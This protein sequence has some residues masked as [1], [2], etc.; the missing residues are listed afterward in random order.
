[1]LGQQIGDFTFGV[2]LL[3]KVAVFVFVFAVEEMTDAFQNSYGICFCRGVLS[4]IDQT[5]VQFV[6]VCKVKVSSYN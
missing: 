6:D 4:Q 3:F 1:M 5:A 2:A